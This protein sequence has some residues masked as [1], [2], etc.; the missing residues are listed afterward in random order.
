MP[1]KKK[2]KKQKK[3]KTKNNITINIEDKITKSELK[4]ELKSPKSDVV[5]L[6]K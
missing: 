6:N 5:S 4:V 2:Q 3:K 1:K